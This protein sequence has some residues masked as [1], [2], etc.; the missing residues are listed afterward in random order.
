M[1]S[2]ILAN[3]S[4]SYEFLCETVAKAGFVFFKVTFGFGGSKAKDDF[5]F[6]ELI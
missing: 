6:D 1:N 2:Y 4:K 3:K 5:I